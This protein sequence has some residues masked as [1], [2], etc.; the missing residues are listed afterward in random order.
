MPILYLPLFI[1]NAKREAFLKY[2]YHG[3][4]SLNL[5]KEGGK[6]LITLAFKE[7]AQLS[8][9]YE[10]FLSVKPKFSFVVKPFNY[11]SSFLNYT[12]SYKKMVL[13]DLMEKLLLKEKMAK[14][15]SLTATKD[16]L[17]AFSFIGPIEEESITTLKTLLKN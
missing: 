11:Y 13:D 16:F 1:I 5:Q 8:F 15:K 4:V 7:L 10:R 9:L 6:T 14:I 2:L 3:L 17:E 12:N